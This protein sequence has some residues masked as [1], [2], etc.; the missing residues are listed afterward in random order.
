MSDISHRLL[1]VGAAVLLA[2]TSAASGWPPIE[3]LADATCL[4]TSQREAGDG[5]VSAHCSDSLTGPSGRPIAFRAHAEVLGLPVLG[6]SVH[7]SATSESASLGRF[8]AAGTANI[9]ALVS[10][11]Q[12][13]T[14]PFGLDFVPLVWHSTGFGEQAGDA[15]FVEGWSRIVSQSGSWQG[16]TFASY[17]DAIIELDDS[18]AFDALLGFESFVDLHVLCVATIERAGASSCSA[19]VT[20]QLLLDQVTFDTRFGDDAF[21][22]ADYFRIEYSPGLTAVPLPPALV[23][24]G[25]ALAWLTCFRTTRQ[26]ASTI[27]PGRS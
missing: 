7:G 8:P 16:I 23:L 18:Y 20:G 15:H 17:D 13:A 14:T 11:V 19:N 12:T 1:F 5:P 22:L 24:L 3:N 26:L 10:L 4:L 27:V 6:V 2:S 21:D 9:R 25:A